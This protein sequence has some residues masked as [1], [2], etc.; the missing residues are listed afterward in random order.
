MVFAPH[1]T[2]VPVLLLCGLVSHAPYP[3][4]TEL[5]VRI[6]TMYAVDMDFAPCQ[7]LACAKQTNGQV[8]NVRYVVFAINIDK[9]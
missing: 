3:Y 2:I 1:Q 7:T 6:S 8:Q 5:I 9:F 4:V